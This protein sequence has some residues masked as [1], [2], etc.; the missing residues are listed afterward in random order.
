[1]V[2]WMPAYSVPVYI[3]GHSVFLVKF[4]DIWY[5]YLGSLWFWCSVSRKRGDGCV[6]GGCTSTL[7]VFVV[8]H[9]VLLGLSVLYS[10]PYVSSRG[11]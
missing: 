9:T 1:M 11:I 2:D 6:I 10:F 4:C 3:R 8:G 5:L 7:L